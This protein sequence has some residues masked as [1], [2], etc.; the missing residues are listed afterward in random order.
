MYVHLSNTET[1]LV[2]AVLDYIG[3]I[4]NSIEDITAHPRGHE[5][6]ECSGKI[7]KLSPVVRGGLA[8]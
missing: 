4:I 8:G 6:N 3:C 5:V 2:C 1:V 7:L